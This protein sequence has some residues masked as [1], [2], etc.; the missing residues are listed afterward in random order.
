MFQIYSENL[1]FAKVA[2]QRI[3]SD[4]A[5]QDATESV[6]EAAEATELAA[7]EAADKLRQVKNWVQLGV[8]VVGVIKAV[9]SLNNAIED[10]QA[11]Q[12]TEAELG[13]KWDQR[14]Y[15][16]DR[17]MDAATQYETALVDPT[18]TPEQLSVLRA[19]Y[20]QALADLE[21]IEAEIQDLI[22]PSDDGGD[23][24]SVGEGRDSDKDER[25]DINP[26]QE[27]VNRPETWQDWP[28][29][30][31]PD[32]QGGQGQPQDRE[33]KIRFLMS[34]GFTRKEAEA[35][36]DMTADGVLSQPELA[37]FEADFP[38]ALSGHRTM[39]LRI[40]SPQGRMENLLNAEAWAAMPD[41][42]AKIDYLKSQGFTEQEASDLADLTSDGT[43][44]NGEAAH[45]LAWS[46]HDAKVA[47]LIISLATN[48]ALN[49][50]ESKQISG[51]A[52]GVWEGS[53]MAFDHVASGLTGGADIGSNALMGHAAALDEYGQ[54]V[55]EFRAEIADAGNDFLADLHY[56]EMERIANDPDNQRRAPGSDD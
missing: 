48:G 12:H 31:T 19:E 10:Y 21:A 4:D 23:G 54:R 15:A 16:L 50:T 27:A 44:A 22:E 28:I 47:A 40:E 46:G 11:A 53:T 32:G 33:A 3:E 25:K 49:G 52:R 41:R 55:D 42:Q 5:S 1:V 13:Q 34:K 6:R 9:D 29:D 45:F 51:G 37:Q 18:S 43:L 8:R 26:R 20:D 7:E 2:V 38:D 35:L 56:R 36:S 30:A 39:Q 24:E 14:D 17:Y